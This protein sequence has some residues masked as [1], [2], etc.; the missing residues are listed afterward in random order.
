MTKGG[1]QLDLDH[2]LKALLR[3]PG[4]LPGATALDATALDQA[5]KA[6]RFT[7]IHD[8]WW[9]GARKA[10]GDTDGTKAL[11]EVLLLHRNLPHE[12]VVAGL[13]AALQAGGYTADVVALEARKANDTAGNDETDKRH[14]HSGSQRHRG[15]LVA[16]RTPTP[17]AP[18]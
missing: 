12:H 7:P 3:K 13:A 2:Y 17:Q 15:H 1:S 5:R 16:H 4:A 11:I 8:E 9:A 6:G 10:R 14:D 18:T